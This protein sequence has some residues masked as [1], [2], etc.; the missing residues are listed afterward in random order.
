[1]SNKEKIKIVN[2]LKESPNGLFD[3][4]DY[5][6]LPREEKDQAKIIVTEKWGDIRPIKNNT[7][8]INPKC[9]PADIL[10]SFIKRFLEGGDAP[11]LG[12]YLY[13][14]LKKTESA[15]ILRSF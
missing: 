14:N 3:E 13:D 8:F 4:Q 10:Q 2:L 11:Q 6:F 7:A 15:V 1:M 12:E 5:L 9:L